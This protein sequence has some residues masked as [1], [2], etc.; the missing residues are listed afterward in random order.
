MMTQPS[1]YLDYLFSFIPK[2][3][4]PIILI[5]VITLSFPAYSATVIPFTINLSETVIVTGSPRVSVNVGGI[6]RFANYASGSGTNALVFN[7]NMVAGDVDLDGVT[8]SSPIDLNSGTM[9]D[10]NGNDANLTFTIPNT[11]NVK[12]NY[13]SLGMD[14]VADADGRY[15]LNGTVYNDLTSFL[16]ASGGSFTRASVGTF[17]NSSGVL[18]TAASGVPRFDYDPTTLVAKGILIE[19]ARTNSLLQSNSFTT[20][21]WDLIT[22]GGITNS[23]STTGAP[24][25]TSVPI[26]NFSTTS[27]LFQDVAVTI[28]NHIT[29]T[30]W[31][32]A[33]QV[34]TIGFRTPGTSAVTSSPL[35]IDTTWKK[36]TLTATA[37]AASSRFLIDNRSSNGFGIAGLQLSLWA[38]QMEVG[39]FSTSYIPTTAA[40]VMRQADILTIPTGAWFNAPQGTAYVEADFLGSGNVG[41]VFALNDNTANNRVDLRAGQS[42]AIISNSG[43]NTNL[44]PINFPLNVAQKVSIAY[45]SSIASASLNGGVIL[46]G[47]PRVPSGINRLRVG[48][49][50]SGGLPL[51][52]RVAEFKYYPIAISNAQLQLMSQ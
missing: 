33:N 45:S 28:G 37:V 32:K 39:A 27:C 6:T 46:T 4:N 11:S 47:I 31:I 34:G 12:V 26:Y 29:H 18:Q 49:I 44:F 52:G 48:N 13:P 41:G 2:I 43:L 25:G 42:Q 22:C 8:L 50:D 14:F 40:S 35:S 24:D 51:G 23:G 1:K 21:P 30:I 15:T 16:T 19:E 5:L 9:K 3:R 7:Y 17:F 10:V 20:P 38:G 36:F